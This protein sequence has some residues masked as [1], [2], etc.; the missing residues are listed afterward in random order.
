MA[1]SDAPFGFRPVKHLNS[2][3]YNGQ[4]NKYSVGASE[5]ALFIGDVVKLSGT[6]DV[7]G[8]P[9]ISRA[10][11]TDTHVLGVIVGFDVDRDNQGRQYW[12]ASTATNSGAT[13]GLYVYVADDPTIIYE[14]QIT[15]I[16][17]TDFGN[18]CDFVATTGSTTTGNSAE[19]L[20]GASFDAGSPAANGLFRVLRAKDSGDNEYYAG[21]PLTV[22]TNPVV[23]VIINAHTYTQQE[24]V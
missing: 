4:Q 3:P 24:E 13:A 6:A 23:E 18:V 2:S 19:E 9:G 5:S 16:S 1:N 17:Q 12:P 20:N 11:I 10:V 8:V 22:I 15:T 14:A 21:S 7:Y